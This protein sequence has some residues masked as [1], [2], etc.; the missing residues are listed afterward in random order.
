MVLGCNHCVPGATL[1]DQ[2]SPGSGIVIFKG[3]PLELLH[4]IS[5]AD[6]FVVKT[7]RFIDAVNRI[8]SSMDKN[9]EFRVGE[10]LHLIADLFGIYFRLG[11][12]LNS[13]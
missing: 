1:P 5:M 11:R 7:P 3:E 10:P 6:F 12:T 2:I 8:N 4:I 9:T 13:R